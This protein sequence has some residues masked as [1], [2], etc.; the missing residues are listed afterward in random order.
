MSGGDRPEASRAQLEAW[1][2]SSLPRA[3]S[4]AA[5]LLR[6]RT[7]ADDVVH[8]CYLRLLRKAGDY[9]LLN[10]G[11]K[12]LFRAVTNA[13]I[14]RNSRERTLL[15]LDRSPAGED[16]E[17]RAVEDLRTSGP[18]QAVMQTELEGMLEEGLGQLPIA[19]RA[20]V[21][22]R[23]LG[24]SLAEIAEALGTSPDNAGVLVHRARKAL[25]GF[26]AGYMGPSHDE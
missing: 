13:C 19:Q 7:A 6:D 25:A 21:E 15:S 11:T 23:S 8:D 14:D 2:L 9:D 18:L 22:L 1:V 24:Y 16:D 20:A 12:L 17:G 26:L 3:V 10:D 4:Y 5:S